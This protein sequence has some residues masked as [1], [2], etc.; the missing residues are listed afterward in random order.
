MREK[1]QAIPRNERRF[2]NA[3]E[4][5]NPLKLLYI[6]GYGITTMIQMGQLV[7]EIFY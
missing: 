2:D 1:E 6:V 7:Y 4:L 3:P 5:R